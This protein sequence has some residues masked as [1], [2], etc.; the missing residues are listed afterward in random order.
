MKALACS[1]LCLSQHFFYSFFGFVY[2]GSLSSSS[3]CRIV[4]MSSYNWPS[5]WSKQRLEQSTS[6]SRIKPHD[7]DIPLILSILVLSIFSS[8][9]CSPSSCCAYICH[10]VRNPIYAD[11]L[12]RPLVNA[13]ISFHELTMCTGLST[14][15]C[16]LNSLLTYSSPSNRIS[17]GR[18]FRC[19]RRSRRYS[20]IGGKRAIGT[21]LNPPPWVP[22]DDGDASSLANTRILTWF[23]Q[24][25]YQACD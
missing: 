6:H 15:L 13:I 5:C 9:H 10:S 21:A 7:I 3:C 23:L 1:S 16:A 25:R 20:G 14:F 2:S 12:V 11:K 19:A 8:R 18:C 22:T 4:F 17:V 24:S